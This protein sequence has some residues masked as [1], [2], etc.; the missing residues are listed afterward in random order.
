MVIQK[1][2]HGGLSAW[3]KEVAELTQPKDVY[4]CDGTEEEWARI[5]G[6]LVTAGT[7]IP[8]K[9]KPNSFWAKSNPNDV[10]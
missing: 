7:L 2:L 8:L 1:L 9:K 3:I 5:T 10:A 4:I 6:E